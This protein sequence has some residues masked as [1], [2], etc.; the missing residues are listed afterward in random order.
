LT[1]HLDRRLT[2]GKFAA[3]GLGKA[4]CNLGSRGIALTRQPVFAMKLFP[5]D[6]NA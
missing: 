5:D 4:G 3:L 2:A 6:S 1:Q